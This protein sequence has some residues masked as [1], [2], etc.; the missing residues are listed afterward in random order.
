MYFKHH[1]K[2]LAWC[3]DK[4]GQF[5]SNFGFIC[6]HPWLSG[7]GWPGIFLGTWDSQNIGS[8]NLGRAWNFFSLAPFSVTPILL[9]NSTSG[10]RGKRIMGYGAIRGTIESAPF[11]HTEWRL[12]ELEWLDPSF[13]LILSLTPGYL[14]WKVLN[15][16][17]S[18]HLV[19]SG[20]WRDLL[21]IS[22]HTKCFVYILSDNPHIRLMNYYYS[23][24]ADFW[25][26]TLS[27]RVSKW[28]SQDSNPDMSDCKGKLFKLLHYT[29]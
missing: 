7:R 3:L 13:L 22:P 23:H 17:G 26:E 10:K 27:H 19:E 9:Q 18:F 11:F 29:L 24:F 6:H 20:Q 2:L 14:A 4:R 16:I 25:T 1:K 8:F 28:L 21:S 15:N 5:L 12:E